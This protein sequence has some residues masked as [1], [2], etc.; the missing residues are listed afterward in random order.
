MASENIPIPLKIVDESKP[1]ICKIIH[2]RNSGTG[3]M[4]H[5]CMC[6]GSFLYGLFTAQH[7][8]PFSDNAR[9]KEYTLEFESL[10]QKFNLLETLNPDLRWSDKMQDAA[11]FSFEKG[12][13]DELADK[14]IKFLEVGKF[15]IGQK[16]LIL[17]HPQG[18]SL[19]LQMGCIVG[20]LG[21][22]QLLHDVATE[23]G[24]AGA[25]LINTKGQVVGIH[26]GKYIP[27]NKNKDEKKDLK[28][29]P[30][31]HTVLGAVGRCLIEQGKIKIVGNLPENPS[32]EWMFD[33]L[34][35]LS[36]QDTN[37]PIGHLYLL[38][39][40]SE[41]DLKKGSELW[42]RQ[43]D[44]YWYWTQFD[45]TKGDTETEW[46]II[47]ENSGF[48]ASSEFD[49]SKTWCQII[50][51]LEKLFAP[52]ARITTNIFSNYRGLLFCSSL[53]F[54]TFKGVV[55]SICREII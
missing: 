31:I 15:E 30:E 54:Q 28:I 7:T 38:P 14:G 1:S 9:L 49:H 22:Y 8:I 34:G 25:P 16:I 26:R 24:S 18:K 55:Y 27:K 44:H 32:T 35:M 23:L 37:Y 33:K 52:V 48:Q 47:N 51:E 21:R 43:T 39:A 5:I 19:S 12:T 11:F 50:L 40:K 53:L 3:F 46:T 41:E 29:A 10:N 42:V 6:N 2:S 13:A 20:E 36:E 4:F 45:L 17:Q